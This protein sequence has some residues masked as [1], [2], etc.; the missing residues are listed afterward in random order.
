MADQEVK[1]VIDTQVLL[2]G[3]GDFQNS[4]AWAVNETYSYAN[5]SLFCS[6]V[7]GYYRD[8]A[9]RYIRPACQWLDGYVPSLHWNG[10]GMISTRIASSLISGLAR[11]IVGEKLVYRVKGKQDAEALKTLQFV[12]T[13]GEENNI[14]KAVKNGIG[15]ALGIGTALLKANIRSN[16]S[17]WWEAV[18]FDN[19]FY[20]ANAS[21]EVID[22]KF[23]LRSYTDT[24]D[25]ADKVQYFLAEHRFF[26]IKQAKIEK[27]PDGTYKAV[28]KKGE[29]VPMV[30]YQVYR[31]N[32]QSLNNL[33]AG[34]SGRS[35]V[36]WSEIP[37]DI[38]RLIKSDYGLIRINEP[39][40]LGF[41]NLGCVALINDEG[42]IAIPTGSNF[43]R[44]LIVAVIDDFI[45]YEVA[46]SYEIRDMYLG[47]GTVYVPKSLNLG[48]YGAGAPIVITPDT[49]PIE[50]TND[51]DAI[52]FDGTTVNANKNN[53]AALSGLTPVFENA[54]TG[55]SN[56]YETIE[57]V[58]P[59]QQQVIVNQFQLRVQEWQQKKENT[60]KSIAV[61]W[62]MSPKI[63]ASFL[64][65]GT[66][67]MT[68]TQIDS[69]D[70]ISIA[71]ITQERACFKGAINKLLETTLNFY[72]KPHNVD[73]E[74]ASPSIVNKDRILD[75]VIKKLEAGLIDL[76]DAIREINPD[77]DEETIQSKIKKAQAAQALAT[78]QAQQEMDQFGE[79]G[80]NYDDNGGENLKGSTSPS[81]RN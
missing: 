56:K 40:K 6:V 70:D 10:S 11:T 32:N 5:S 75:R 39:Q 61:K 77:L 4:L 54:L 58:D 25:G 62:G 7:A 51:P 23:L 17:V 72:G 79:F 81:Q 78:L 26:E 60:L 18:R 57:G 65:Q 14:K 30:E 74:F 63:L 33:M 73:I 1:N 43:G 20:L 35:N 16:Q 55:V 29:K 49:K 66:V 38:R 15:F 47:K 3:V 19:C 64:A 2:A 36:N 28:S 50:N 8:Y 41:T 69:E 46:E 22:A 45:Q 44:S 53:A 34:A 24:R 59:A 67:Q 48:S 80:N 37:N 12:S 27:K 21:N 13:W 68:A 52:K 9:W 71:F 31:A 76:E 42:D